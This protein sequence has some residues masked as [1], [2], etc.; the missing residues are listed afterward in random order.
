MSNLW[1]SWPHLARAMAG[2]A[3]LA[4]FASAAE[5]ATGAA[6]GELR[7][8]HIFGDNMV[9]QR[10]REIP[11]W[12]WAKPGTTVHVRLG[13]AD[14]AAV[15]GP[16]GKWLAR[17]PAQKAGG[18]LELKAEAEGAVTLTCANVL[19]GDVW[20]CSGQSNMEMGL[21]GCLGAEEDVKTADLPQIRW[22]KIGGPAAAAPVAD[23]NMAGPWGKWV[24]ASPKTAMHFTGVG[25][26]FAREVN[27]ETGVPIGLIDDS[28]SGTSIG[29]WWAPE[30]LAAVPEL[31]PVIKT[32]QQQ[33]QD[34]HK[35]LPAA[36]DAREAW[37]KSVRDALAAPP[38]PVPAPAPVAGTGPVAT[39]TATVVV[40][41]N[42]DSVKRLTAA[43]E[44]QDA[45]IK[46]TRQ[47]LVDNGALNASP[48][49]PGDFAATLTSLTA[50][51]ELATP[52]ALPPN[53]PADVS[54]VHA[55]YNG[56]IRPLLPF[57]IRGVL[58][59]QGENNGMEGDSYFQKMRA[60]IGGWRTVWGQGEFPFYFVQLP[61]WQKANDN[62]AGGDGWPGIRAAQAKALSIANTGMAVTID[63]G[64]A[65]E[66]HPKNKYDVG[67]RLALW[68]LARDYGRKDVVYSGPMFREFK[69]EDG[70][71]RLFFDQLGGGLMVGKKDGR[72]AA[73]PDPDGKLARFAVAGED[74]VW[75][76]ADAKIEGDTVLVSSEKVPKPAAVRYAY[77]WNPAGA[78]L[79]NRAGLPACPFRTDNW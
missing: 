69:I 60:L 43:L 16:D 34:Y 33:Q 54:S 29:P 71:A 19:V 35:A 58:W 39:G 9:L 40:T 47:A 70:K 28:W 75:Y 31:E 6:A 11:V 63:V 56:R 18:P 13:E 41:P 77:S 10:E 74:K 32:I 51:K 50:R 37:L 7:L 2:A 73:T 38:A 55:I 14:A 5:P 23:V 52:P 4:C 66:I 67:H 72:A 42:P 57:A 68:A 20:L 15:A 17:L 79:Y 65:T 78:N 36:L 8:A 44:A 22:A 48:G 25:F 21:G 62:P 46:A 1:N 3:L 53:G 61:A 26:Y 27:H 76:W 49:L 64:D 24:A 45:W 12:G 30:G 59:Y